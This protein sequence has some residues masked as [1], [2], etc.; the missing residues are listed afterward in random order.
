[1]KGI[2]I[3]VIF[4]ALIVAALLG[5][6]VSRDWSNNGTAIQ[7]VKQMR[8][9]EAGCMPLEAQW[10]WSGTDLPANIS[11]YLRAAAVSVGASDTAETPRDPE[12]RDPRLLAWFRAL[13]LARQGQTEASMP[14]LKASGAGQVFLA[15][16][17]R[18]YYTA[19]ACTVVNWVLAYEIGNVS[20][21]PDPPRSSVIVYVEG[22]IANG[23][24]QAVIDA[25]TRLLAFEP[26]KSDWRLTLAKAY[27]T[28]KQK[29]MAEQVLQ[30]LL[31][32]PE[33]RNAAEA[34]LNKYQE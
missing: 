26:N 22:L 34:L 5:L 23:Q 21:S 18:T 2:R 7:V 1:M 33:G 27:L 24:A 17:H 9:V 16:G 10:T 30:P 13:Q 15:A 12:R 4:G 6:R 11:P 8:P 28:L 19:P 3:P 29:S 25:Y 20:P 14:Y 31:T 32:S